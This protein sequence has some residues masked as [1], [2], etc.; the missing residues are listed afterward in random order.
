MATERSPTVPTQT[1][2][3]PSSSSSSSSSSPLSSI[4]KL[5]VLFQNK[6]IAVVV[7]PPGIPCHP[8]ECRKPP[9]SK[10][11]RRHHT[12]TTNNNKGKGDYKP[13]TDRDDDIPSYTVIDMARATF[14][15]KKNDVVEGKSSSKSNP[16]TEANAQEQGHGHALNVNEEHDDGDDTTN[17]TD[18][19]GGGDDDDYDATTT[20]EKI[21]LVHR[22]DAP[23][24]G[25]LMLA[26]STDAVRRASEIFNDNAQKTYFALC[27]GDGV[28]LR[29]KGGGDSGGYIVLDG[30]VKDAK[31][32]Q[33]NAE[34]KI[35]CWMGSDGHAW[36]GRR[37]C[38]V[39]AVPIT[40]RY[41]Q[42]RSHLGRE[43]H[44]LVG[45]TQHHKDIKENRAWKEILD[46]HN[47]PQRPCLHCHRIVVEDTKG[48]GIFG[49]NKPI[50]D[51]QCPLSDELQAMIRLTDWADTAH[52]QLPQLFV[53]LAK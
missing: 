30:D 13:S 15:P 4:P 2:A 29:R 39:E 53:P 7:K 22:L 28:A 41:H 23:T 18:S 48:T 32:I 12:A 3:A 1:T 43:H 26:F 24:S 42:I 19:G 21:H 14:F 17:Q 50:L 11:R 40:G 44:P 25:C 6:D 20:E 37:C 38:L 45:E 8:W 33:R 5:T 16:K 34:T 10:K 31:G 47:I 35:R 9:S 51:V 27:R 52:K 49:T 36:N 46:R